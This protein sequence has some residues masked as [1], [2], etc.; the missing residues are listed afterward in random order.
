[1]SHGVDAHEFLIEQDR[2][3]AEKSGRPLLVVADALIYFAVL[4][5]LFRARYRIGYRL[6][7]PMVAPNYAAAGSQLAR[8]SGLGQEGRRR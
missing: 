3:I 6:I 1:M 4:A 2:D 8:Q 5:A 7:T